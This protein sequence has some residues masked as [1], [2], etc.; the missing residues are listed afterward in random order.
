MKEGPQRGQ[1]VAGIQSSYLVLEEVCGQAFADNEGASAACNVKADGSLSMSI[2]TVPR[3][4]LPSAS[5]SRIS[6]SNMSWSSQSHPLG[7]K[8]PTL[9]PL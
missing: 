2:S 3:R 6:R 8:C 5:P 4:S 9:G 1:G 7:L